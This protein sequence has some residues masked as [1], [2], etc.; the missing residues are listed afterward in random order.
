MFT[1]VVECQANKGKTEVVARTVR[2][3]VLPTLQKQARLY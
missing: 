3:E 1:R 2:N